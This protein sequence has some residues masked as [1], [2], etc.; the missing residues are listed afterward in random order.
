MRK[1]KPNRAILA[2]AAAERKA[3]KAAKH[4]AVMAKHEQRRL[5]VA[6]HEAA[7]DLWV[8]A[9]CVGPMPIHPDNVGMGTGTRQSKL[10]DA[11][12]VAAANELGIA[13]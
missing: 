6:I 2:A 5:A 3:E 9:D 1:S 10:D 8:A 12:L 7:W 13:I 4:A 11:D